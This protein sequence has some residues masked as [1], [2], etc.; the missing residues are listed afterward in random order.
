MLAMQYSFT[1]P[2]DYD[3]EIIRQRIDLYGHLMD[4][5][6][7]LNFKAY[8]WSDSATATSV[9]PENL[10]APFYVWRNS[11]GLNQFLAGPGFRALT[12]AFGWP[13]V[14]IWPIWE[15]VGPARVRE[16]RYATRSITRIPSYSALDTLRGKSSQ[17]ARDDIACHGALASLVAFDPSEWNLLR[18]QLW[19]DMPPESTATSQRYQVGHVSA[20]GH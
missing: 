18:L 19:S 9:T 1:L 2:A 15:V 13:T 6:P 8:L 7:D 14:R 20:P 3:M 12:Q 17:Q 10:Y 5:F 11:E 4:D 16:A